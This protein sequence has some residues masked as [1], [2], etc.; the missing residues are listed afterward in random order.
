M[1]NIE[2]L[3]WRYA[4]KKF[5]ENKILPKEKIDILKSAFNLT[6]TSYG[7]QPIKLVLV[8]NKDLQH[9]LMEFSW[10]QKQ[11]STASHVLIF[12]IEKNIDKKF[13]ET[14][15]EREKEIR[16]TPDEIIA[17][18]KEFLLK[19]FGRK[20]EEEIKIW[21]LNQAYLALGT[22]LTVCATEK[23]DSCPMEGFS[24]EKYNELLN[25]KERN[26]E[27]VLVL[28]VGYRAADD[29]FSSLKK[30]RKPL[31]EVIVEIN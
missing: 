2:A 10:G 26:L 12:C 28:P 15:F 30:V 25:L 19:D 7:L 29:M 18:Y 23:I 31:S 21:A 4:T 16:S 24:P 3:Q 17:P 11:I 6:A 9:K 20:P 5:D 13:I 14:Y 8:Q 1:E 22:L 27:S